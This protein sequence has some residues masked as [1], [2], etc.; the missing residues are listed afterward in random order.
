MFAP[1][2]DSK[3]ILDSKHFLDFELYTVSHRYVITTKMSAHNDTMFAGSARL[4]KCTLSMELS[5]C[6]CLHRVF[7]SYISSQLASVAILLL[8]LLCDFF[9]P[10]NHSTSFV[11]KDS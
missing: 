5:I 11:E 10:F 8:F 3:Y 4:R 7:G 9:L 1:L 2:L 6:I